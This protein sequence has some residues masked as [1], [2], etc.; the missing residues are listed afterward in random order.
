MP[1]LAALQARMARALLSGRFDDIVRHMTPGP[2]PAADALSVHRGTAVGGLVN[3][4][5]LSHPTVLAL[6]GEDFFDQAA[7]AFV[8]SAPPAS[9]SLTSYGEG[10]AI[11]LE[12]YDLAK[13]LPYL[14]DVAR[15]DFAL[16]QA[17]SAAIGDDGPGL[18]LGEAVLTLDASL[19]L[20]ELDYPADAIR[21]AL[22]EDEDRLAAIDMGRRRRTLALWRLPDGAGVRVLSPVSSPFVAAMLAGED[23]SD[24]TAPEAELAL[25]SAEVF[26]APFARLSLKPF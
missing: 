11:F 25:L 8:Q 14:A 2:V 16:D 24:F 15:F 22:A 9:A 21:D 13:G 26:T 5:R 4:L 17:A 20:I 3:A 19:R 7:R 18:D 12:A 23:L 10:F 1:D 6:V